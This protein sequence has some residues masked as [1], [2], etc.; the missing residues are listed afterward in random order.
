MNNAHVT[1]FDSK[2]D[3]PLGILVLSPP[4]AAL[5]VLAAGLARG[6]VVLAVL[7]AIIGCAVVALYAAF[8]IPVRYGI[9]ADTLIIQSGRRRLVV[10]LDSVIGVAPT[11]DPRS[12]PALSLDR[13]EICIA[14]GAEPVLIISPANRG[15]FLDV[16][17]SRSGMLRRGEQLVRDQGPLDRP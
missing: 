1:W 17:A 16:L 3:W 6:D 15:E 2:V 9:A 4:L 8:V 5:A 13:L 11:T 12:S 10:S 7:A 14:P